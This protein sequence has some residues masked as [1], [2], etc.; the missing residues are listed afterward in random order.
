VAVHVVRAVRVA[1]GFSLR[2]LAERADLD[3]A[4]IAR[5][6]SGMRANPQ[7]VAKL[8]RGLGVRPTN[9]ERAIALSNE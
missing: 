6:E 3:H 7:Q 4:Q 2:A 5:I 1:K 8:A 9:L